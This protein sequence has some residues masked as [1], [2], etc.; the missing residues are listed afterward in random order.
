MMSIE[1]KDGLDKLFVFCSE[2]NVLSLKDSKFI[3][4]GQ[5]DDAMI[6]LK[7]GKWWMTN[8]KCTPKCSCFC[9]CYCL[10]HSHQRGD[11]CNC[12]FNK[13]SFEKVLDSVS[14]ELQAQLLFHLDVFI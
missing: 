14:S 10:K 3:F 2:C 6:N 8:C 13:T 11:R 4:V 9:V 5:V 7:E 12:P 1:F